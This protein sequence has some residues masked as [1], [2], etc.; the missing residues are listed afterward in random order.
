MGFRCDRKKYGFTWSCPTD[1]DVHPFDKENV[2][3][4][5]L[6]ELQKLASLKW[7]TIAREKH[8]RGCWHYHAS[9]EFEQKY[10]TRDERFADIDGVHPNI[11]KPGKGWLNYCK[12]DGDFISN[13]EKCVFKRARD[14]DTWDEARD[15]L[16]ENPK[17]MLQFGESAERNWKRRRIGDCL[18]VVYHGPSIRAPEDWDPAKKTLVIEGASG[19]GKTQ[20]ALDFGR[21]HGGYLKV[22]HY[23]KLKE[24]RG[25]P[26]IIFDDCDDSLNDQDVST[27]ISITETE[28]TR[29][30]RVLH[31]V[32]TIPPVIKIILT[33][34]GLSPRD[35]RAGAVNRR[36]FNWS[37]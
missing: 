20:W 25:Q 12:K 28:S 6:Q 34:G 26:V 2:L 31:G 15:I 33:N 29:D 16:W 8:E 22:G 17:F 1:V 10:C 30:F 4:W 36:I 7:Y 3:E 37:W 27:W 21:R 35:N 32:V 18:D 14:A 19:I 5:I 9:I 13:Y 23:Q 24:W 11:I